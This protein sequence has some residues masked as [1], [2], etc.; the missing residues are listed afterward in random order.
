LTLRR[1]VKSPPV[2]DF[3][4]LFDNSVDEI[5][6]TLYLPLPLANL[7]HDNFVNNEYNPHNE[8]KK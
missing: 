7:L 1:Q 4:N 6:S 2:S 5:K 8:N 3:S